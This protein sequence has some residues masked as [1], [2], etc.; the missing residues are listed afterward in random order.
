MTG[1]S[2][3]LDIDLAGKTAL[4]RVDYNVP[5]HPSTTEISDDSRIVASLPTL[6]YLIDQKCRVVLCSHLGRPNGAVTDGLH[7][8][9]VSKRLSELLDKQVSQLH[10]CVGPNVHAA[11]RAM[12]PREV[13]MLENLR[14]HKG[15]EA[16]DISFA[17]D[18]SSVA[19]VYVNDAFG[20]AHRAHAS[21]AGVARFLPAVAG[22]LM[23]RELK[24]LGVALGSPR[25]PF[26]AILGGAKVSDKIPALRNLGGKV[27]SLLIGGGMAATFLR[28]RRISVGKS[29]VEENLVNIATDVIAGARKRGV[30]ILLPVDVV[31]AANFSAEAEYRVADVNDI[32]ETWRIMD[33][34][35]RTIE[36]YERVLDLARTIIWNGPLG[37]HE[38]DN[39]AKGTTRVAKKLSRMKNAT[40]LLGG[41][42]TAEAI[43]ALGLAREMTHVSTGG[44][45]SLEL[46]EGKT[47][48]GVAALMDREGTESTT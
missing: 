25:R 17:H 13:I 8:A 29:E 20:V 42:S 12:E 16:N 14:F 44:G 36:T 4:V 18:L 27:D 22:L 10:E 48:P 45:A 26:V 5:F 11:V 38:W 32:P 28:A 40:T 46:L 7:M 34:G 9:P 39:F 15:E 47:L 41:G 31:L 2:T 37:V 19:D 30:E 21:T 23:Q 24:Y 6:R 33:I 3:L 35:P 43:I 1:K